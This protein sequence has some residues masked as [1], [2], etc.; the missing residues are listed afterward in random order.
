[1]HAHMLVLSD[2]PGVIFD[3]DGVLCDSEPFI[4]EAA[5][6]MFVRNHGIA[7]CAQDF[8]PFV[9]TGE[10]RYL[11]GVAEKHGVSLDLERDKKATYDIYLEIAA[12]RAAGLKL[13]VATSADRVKLDGNLHEIGIPP[14][15]FDARVNG[16]EVTNKKPHPEIFLLAAQRLGLA[17]ERCLVI[18]D[19]PSGIQA[20]RAA[21]AKCLGLTTSFG[22][23]E[24]RAAGADWTAPD[25][26]QVLAPPTSGT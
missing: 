23:A 6:R 12:C 11:G 2:F 21:G 7:V 9:G 24:L 25:L 18:E 14:E 16:L 17:A 22:P 8:V 13:A 20:G 1:M 5:V 10:N 4:C 3:M 15:T 26:A 19:A